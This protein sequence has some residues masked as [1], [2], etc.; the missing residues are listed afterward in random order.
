MAAPGVAADSAPFSP[1]SSPFERSLVV[2]GIVPVLGEQS[3]RE[4]EEARLAS[5]EAIAARRISQRA[6]A[7]LDGTAARTLAHTVFPAL[8]KSRHAGPPPMPHGFSFLS[9][10]GSTAALVALPDGRHGVV[11]SPLPMAIRG[12]DN[13]YS[14]VNLSLR[15]S[16]GGFEP[17]TAPTGL[18]LP[19][20]LG[21]GI[22]M[23]HGDL[24]LTPLDAAGT[25]V[26]SSEGTGFEGSVFYAD[27]QRD[28]DTL[29]Q[30][31]TLGFEL[32]M[33]LRS[34]SSPR[35][36]TYRVTLPGGVKLVP[37]P[38]MRG[39]LGVVSDGTTV[40]TILAPTAHDAAGTPVPVAMTGSGD[41]LTLSVARSGESVQYPVAIDPEVIDSTV[42]N[43]LYNPTRW[44]FG[45]PGA[46]HFTA[47][48]W[49]LEV[50]VLESTG[51]YHAGEYG[52]LTYQTQG[53][54][55]IFWGELET[56]VQNP[57]NVETELQL[58]HENPETHAEEAEETQLLTHPGEEINNRTT[59]QLCAEYPVKPTCPIGENWYEYGA[60]HNQF[61]L[62]ESAAAEGTGWNHANIEQ[63]RV[64]ID[65]TH[66]PEES[67]NT[68]SPT[69]SDGR[70]NVFYGSGGWLGE[71]NGAFEAHVKDRGVGVSFFKLSD[72]GGLWEL[73]HEIFEEGKCE[74]V[75]CTPEVNELVT[76]AGGMPEGEHTLVL[77]SK[78]KALAEPT[79]TNTATL[80]VDNEPPEKL[81][82]TGLPASGEVNEEPYQLKAE[83]T[84]GYGSTKS[85][86]V[87]SIKLAVDGREL[88]GK[89]SGSCTPGPCTTSG[90]WTLSAEGLGAGKNTLT[91]IAT[92]HAGNVAT[93]NYEF[94]ARHSTPIPVGPGRVNPT[95]GEMGLT[96]T[97]VAINGGTGNLG[98]SRSYGSRHLTA[99]EEGPL[100]PQWALVLA[101]QENLQVMPDGSVMLVNASATAATHFVKGT[102]GKFISPEGDANLSLT[103]GKEGEKV[104]YI[105][106]STFVVSGGD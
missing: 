106:N 104:I 22:L 1:A 98:V 84:D 18:R 95:N 25:P 29:V 21:T 103:E 31:T 54:S 90:E 85:S 12:S 69:L 53:E 48:G 81:T 14:P 3:V 52:F 39:A 78:D 38:N 34:A 74:G 75:Q 76:Y 60:P 11:E 61:K 8:F 42:A 89:L 93:K 16:N 91:V 63:A 15:E 71:H 24:S 32:D 46:P 80:K 37:E 5:P 79:G 33:I 94:T 58:V 19:K 45:P 77:T 13:H 23:R 56:K 67:F 87:A 50:L 30:P 68:T 49:Y 105:L 2:E 82:V 6:Y 62:Q 64:W 51:T 44:K 83:A 43:K 96:S 36:L 97:D 4:A 47:T 72:G 102:N 70:P 57:G 26:S 86:G 10:L 65:Q 92:D 88:I 17:T 99:G 20:K 40:A 27:T 73:K 101:D 66:G 55:H 41:V 7:G 100:G 9:F 28:S 35:V 59:E